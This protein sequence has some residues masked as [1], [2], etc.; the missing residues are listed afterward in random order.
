M[1]VIVRLPNKGSV[2]PTAAQQVP[3]CGRIVLQ[4]GCRRSQCVRTQPVGLGRVHLAAVEGH[5]AAL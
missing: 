3:Q 1:A 2:L 5:R 4:I